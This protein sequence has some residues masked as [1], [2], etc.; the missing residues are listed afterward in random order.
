MMGAH[1]TPG[2]FCRGPRRAGSEPR[3]LSVA[4]LARGLEA[5]GRAR[6]RAT[7]SRRPACRRLAALRRS[8]PPRGSTEESESGGMRSIRESSGEGTP[9]ARSPGPVLYAT[10]REAG[11]VRTRR[12]V[13]P[14][15][16]AGEGAAE[17]APRQFASI[18]QSAVRPHPSASAP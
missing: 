18:D 7:C 6:S 11:S 8:A 16:Q 9:A 15:L 2:A 4:M 3:L 12:A 14:G 5:L 1:Q 13:L 10:G 17:R